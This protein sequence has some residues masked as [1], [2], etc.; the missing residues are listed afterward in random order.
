MIVLSGMDH[1]TVSWE[2]SNVETNILV[3][4]VHDATTVQMTLPSVFS[5]SITA[6]DGQSYSAGQT[7][8]V[9][10]KTTRV[11]Y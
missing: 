2:Y 10:A 3:V 7:I 1:Y 9:S 4:G 6:V 8:T 11:N 5:G